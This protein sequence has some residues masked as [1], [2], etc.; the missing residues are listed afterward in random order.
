MAISS[1][2]SANSQYQQMILAQQVAKD[3]DGDSDGDGAARVAQAAPAAKNPA[4]SNLAS[5]VANRIDV[6]A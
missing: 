4:S 3:S 6:M 2:S 1:V 5:G